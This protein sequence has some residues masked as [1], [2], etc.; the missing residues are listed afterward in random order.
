M[1]TLPHPWT[2]TV[3]GRT[4]LSESPGVLLA[5]PVAGQLPCGLV[6][7]A[8]YEWRGHGRVTQRLA[9]LLKALLGSCLQLPVAIWRAAAEG[10]G[11]ERRGEGVGGTVGSATSNV[12]QV[13]TC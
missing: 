8:A 11:W 10:D 12:Y 4:V 7:V 9:H 3:C 5:G 6:T 13:E 2:S 1:C